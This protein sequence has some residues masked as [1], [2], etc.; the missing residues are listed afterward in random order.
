M[1][2]FAPVVWPAVLLSIAAFGQFEF[3]SIVGVVTD[4]TKAPVAGA[5]V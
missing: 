2:R 4:P 5:T 1:R 3:G